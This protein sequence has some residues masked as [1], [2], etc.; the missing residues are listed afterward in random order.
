MYSAEIAEALPGPAWLKSQRTAAAE[1]ASS[2]PLPTFEA[3]EWRY[4]PIDDFRPDAFGPAATAPAGDAPKPFAPDGASI[5]VHTVDGFVSSIDGPGAKGLDVSSASAGSA[6]LDLG[7]VEGV[8]GEANTAFSP[9]P[10]VIRV[11]A[12][13]DVEGPVVVTHDI[14][15]GGV[16]A[17]PRVEVEVG[18]DASVSVVEVFRSAAV[19]ALVVPVTNINC[20]GASRVRYQQVQ[21]LG[22]E[23]WQLGSLAANVEQQAN[24]VGGIAAMGASYGRLRTDCRLVGRGAS[25]DLLALY[26][27]DG[28]QT[29]DF[30]T[31]QDHL[32]RDTSSNLLFKG[33]LDDASTSVYTG[34]I[35]VSPDGAG[36]NAVQTNRNI[37]LSEDAWAESVPNLEIENNDVHCSHAS[38]VSPVD[39]EQLFYLESRGVPTAAAERLIVEGFL[40]EIISELPVPVVADRVAA[41]VQEKLDRREA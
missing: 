4:S 41:M 39:E 22:R 34:L 11:A 7:A 25:G 38:A 10:I 15:T 27:G 3:E 40:A 1:R 31:F 37:K 30:R 26:F 2:L 36:T 9:D 6:E 24:F 12:G 33:V 32:A 13:R 28:D 29:L 21:E 17:F 16:A 8:F 35:R 23:V 5:V 20:G 19:S 14:Q 18:G